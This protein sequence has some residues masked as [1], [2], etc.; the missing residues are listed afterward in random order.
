MTEG[1]CVRLVLEVKVNLFFCGKPTTLES[2][3]TLGEMSLKVK[4]MIGIRY[5]FKKV[6]VS[7]SQ[8][9]TADFTENH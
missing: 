6:N 3:E 9:Q 7:Q 1:V 2:E 5:T 4:L 8:R